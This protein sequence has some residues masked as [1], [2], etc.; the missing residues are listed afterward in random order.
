MNATVTHYCERCGT[1]GTFVV[2]KLSLATPPVR[3]AFCQ[4]CTNVLECPCQL[5]LKAD[6]LRKKGLGLP[7]T[8]IGCA[9]VLSI[10]ILIV[11]LI[12]IYGVTGI[13]VF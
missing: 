3:G 8:D 10:V 4:A 11:V 7:G 1:A 13:R 5:C 12:V 9:V 6:P 2:R